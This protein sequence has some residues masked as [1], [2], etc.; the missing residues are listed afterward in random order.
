[1]QTSAGFGLDHRD[2]EQQSGRRQPVEETHA[3]MQRVLSM[4]DEQMQEVVALWK[5]RWKSNR[6]DV[7]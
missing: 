7:A 6:R 2:R 4:S 1:M 3:R 5:S